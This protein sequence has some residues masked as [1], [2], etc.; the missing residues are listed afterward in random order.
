MITIKNK[1]KPYFVGIVYP[2][3]EF[4]CSIS[5]GYTSNSLVRGQNISYCHF[6]TYLKRKKPQGH[7][8]IPFFISN[9]FFD[10]REVREGITVDPPVMDGLF[11]SCGE[12]MSFIT[13][14][15]HVLSQSSKDKAVRFF[16]DNGYDVVIP[17]EKINPIFAK[18]F[19]NKKWQQQ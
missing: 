16:H 4:A 12:E 11:Y 5:R 9:V 15:F 1:D 14:N 6:I 8:F 17:P 10:A 18:N 2:L 3:E 13:G 19:L 7:G